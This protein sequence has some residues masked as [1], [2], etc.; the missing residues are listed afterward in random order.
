MNISF[1]KHPLDEQLIAGLKPGAVKKELWE[2]KLYLKY[3]FMIHD[4]A[5]RH[6]LNEDDISM[7]YSD[8]ILTTINNISAGRFEHRSSLQT[9]ISNIFQYKLIDRIRLNKAAKAGTRFGD[10]LDDHLETLPGDTRDIVQKLTEQYEVYK[11]KG[12]IQMMDDRC[13]KII[14][15]WGEGYHDKEIASDL[16]YLS[17]AVAKTSRLRCLSKLKNL[18]AVKAFDKSY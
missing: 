16:G 9:Y 5:W 3:R 11:L 8:A 13:K 7:A 2:T 12:F 18:Y 4:A 14:L 15:A 1:K 17:A 6:Q 10:S